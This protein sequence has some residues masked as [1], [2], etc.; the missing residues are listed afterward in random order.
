MR[1]ELPAAAGLVVA[2]EG[3]FERGRRVEFSFPGG[4]E[5][6]DGLLEPAGDG[7]LLF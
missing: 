7:F 3:G 5:R 1:H 2:G 4:G 6:F